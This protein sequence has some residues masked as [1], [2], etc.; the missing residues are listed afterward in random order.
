[1]SSRKRRFSRGLRLKAVVMAETHASLLFRPVMPLI[2]LFLVMFY[3]MM[4]K[5][6]FISRRTFD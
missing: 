2:D 3:I 6:L 5:N 4:I 1:M